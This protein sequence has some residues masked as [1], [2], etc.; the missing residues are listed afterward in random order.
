MAKKEEI[1]FSRCNFSLI[2]ST[3]LLEQSRNE[4]PI[5][6]DSVHFALSDR[7]PSAINSDFPVSVF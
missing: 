7:W 3:D 6:E 2:S 1:C 5:R 4:E